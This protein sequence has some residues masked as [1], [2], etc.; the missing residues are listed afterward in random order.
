MDD[1]ELRETVESIL[2]QGIKL[3]D[4]QKT[5]SFKS[6]EVLLINGVP[7]PLVGAEGDAV[8]QALL[9]G[10]V[11][12]SEIVNS[13]LVSAGIWR[14]PVRVHAEVTVKSTTL[15]RDAISVS[16][17]GR[18]VEERCK[19][20]REEDLVHKTS[21]EIWR[22]EPR[23]TNADAPPDHQPGVDQV[24]RAEKPS[25]RLVFQCLPTGEGTEKLAESQFRAPDA[26]LIRGDLLTRRGYRFSSLSN[27][28]P[29]ARPS[30][31]E[32]KHSLE[33][34]EYGNLSRSSQHGSPERQ[35]RHPRES[36]LVAQRSSIIHPLSPVYCVLP[37]VYRGGP[38]SCSA[39]KMGKRFLW[40]SFHRRRGGC[41]SNGAWH[42]R[43]D[44]PRSS[45]RSR[46]QRGGPDDAA[47]LNE[48][49]AGAVWRVF[50]V[51]ERPV[52]NV[53]IRLFGRCAP[54]PFI[55]AAWPIPSR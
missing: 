32:R 14:H 5:T 27:K 51:A 43:R 3:L 40:A 4:V 44:A 54:P 30:E 52:A 15:S 7:V 53:F 50:L 29:A 10:Q 23:T 9:N 1:V 17:N 16:R 8:R 31:S 12:P 47:S 34:S 20:T 11:P 45:E 28:G 33:P 48:E 42:V 38:V 22:S 18:L 2:G 6:E 13:L 24:D 41:A 49:A 55:G 36:A 21:T 26:A 46:A 39:P 35:L 25:V 19:E 37:S